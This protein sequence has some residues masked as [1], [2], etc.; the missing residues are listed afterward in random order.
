MTDH[1]AIEL[2]HRILN[3]ATKHGDLRLAADAALL[4]AKLLSSAEGVAPRKKQ[5]NAK[6]TPN[7]KRNALK[8]IKNGET[9]ASV[10]ASFKVNPTT[11]FRL[12]KAGRLTPVE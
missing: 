8:R 11:I 10:A 3:R 9:I 1:T 2:A 6:L 4:L 7:D 5:P 12:K